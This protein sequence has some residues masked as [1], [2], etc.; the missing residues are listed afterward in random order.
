MKEKVIELI[1][2]WFNQFGQVVAWSTDYDWNQPE[3]VQQFAFLLKN[4][5]ANVGNDLSVPQQSTVNYAL[6]FLEEIQR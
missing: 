1:K 6:K 5:L 4:R 3:S 2:A